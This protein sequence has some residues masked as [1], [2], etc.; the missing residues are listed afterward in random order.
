MSKHKL[1][2]IKS[3]LNELERQFEIPGAVV[4]Y[5]ETETHL[6]SIISTIKDLVDVLEAK[7]EK[8]DNFIHKQ[9]TKD[10]E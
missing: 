6:L 10:S 1:K 9:E 2:Q 3:Q 4:E 5:T 7:C 8:Y